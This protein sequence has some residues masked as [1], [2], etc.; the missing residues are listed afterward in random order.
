MGKNTILRASG[1]GDPKERTSSAVGMPF[2]P[3]G[4]GQ[5]HDEAMDD[6]TCTLYILRVYLR[7]LGYET[8]YL[9]I[10]V[11]R[12]PHY[13]HLCEG[14]LPHILQH[15]FYFSRWSE[16]DKSESPGIAWFLIDT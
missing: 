6:E 11:R 9:F 4:V 15:H 1:I 10:M 5:T 14:D 2:G 13:R 16:Y 12:T 7:M 8:E 3:T